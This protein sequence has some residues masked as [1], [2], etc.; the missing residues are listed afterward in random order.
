MGIKAPKTPRETGCEE[1]CPL[2]AVA[3][4]DAVTHPEKIDL[5]MTCFG[6]F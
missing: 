4:E 1:K 6:V 3:G 5:E 2:P